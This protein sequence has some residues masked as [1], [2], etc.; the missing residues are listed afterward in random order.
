ME[1]NTTLFPNNSVPEFL[2][3]ARQISLDI[4]C[5][6]QWRYYIVFDTTK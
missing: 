5:S 3:P 6:D 1:V 4:D 2:I